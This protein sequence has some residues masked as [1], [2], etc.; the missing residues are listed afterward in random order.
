MPELLPGRIEQRHAEVG[1]ARPLRRIH[2]DLDH[3]A[4]GP[5]RHDERQMRGGSPRRDD[6][7]TVRC[8]AGRRCAAA[9]TVER[10]VGQRCAA[11]RRS[12]H[13]ARQRQMTGDWDS[14]WSVTV[15][16]RERRRGDHGL[17][18]RRGTSSPLTAYTAAAVAGPR[19]L[20]VAIA[21]RHA[22]RLMQVEGRRPRAAD[23]HVTANGRPLSATKKMRRTAPGEGRR[24]A[25]ARGRRDGRTTTVVTSRKAGPA[26][27]SAVHPVTTAVYTPGARERAPRHR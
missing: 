3:H 27:V 2:G 20:A 16:R 25:T 8:G 6:R 18:R 4:A 22:A 1:E 7:L 11:R 24:G 9:R 26:I 23:S 13:V 21:I 17:V 15:G 5:G 14:R 10:R 19:G 12:R